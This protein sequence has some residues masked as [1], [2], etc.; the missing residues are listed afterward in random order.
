MT[1]RP[2]SQ[3]DWT[4]AQPGDRAGVVSRILIQYPASF[5]A[6]GS[7]M[8]EERILDKDNGVSTLGVV[9]DLPFSFGP[10]DF[11]PGTEV[12]IPLKNPNNNEPLGSSIGLR[13]AYVTL[14]SLCAYI[15]DAA[16]ARQQG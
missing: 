11:T 10:A 9:A 14:Y 6:T 13:Q 2:L 5:T 7:V 3:L 4:L 12:M 8:I 16:I 1:T 15:R